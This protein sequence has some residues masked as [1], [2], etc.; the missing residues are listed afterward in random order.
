MNNSNIIKGSREIRNILLQGS[1]RT[2]GRG[3]VLL[4]SNILVVMYIASY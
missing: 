2:R 4:E 3:T 1:C